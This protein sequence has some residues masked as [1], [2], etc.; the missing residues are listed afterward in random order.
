MTRWTEQ[1]TAFLRNHYHADMS[2]AVI[3]EQL[4]ISRNAV[5]GKAR[6]LGL[7]PTEDSPE[8]ITKL[9]KPVK[10]KKQRRKRLPRKDPL[11]DEIANRYR[12]GERPS[13]IAA[14]LGVSDE[15]VQSVRIGRKIPPQRDNSSHRKIT[16]S[17]WQMIREAWER[18]DSVESIAERLGGISENS[19]RQRLFQAG[20]R[21]VQAVARYAA[22]CTPAQKEILLHQGEAAFIAAMKASDEAERV[23]LQ[24]AKA[25]RRE[26]NK[27]S[28]RHAVKQAERNG[29]F[30][31]MSR[32][33]IIRW[34][35]E[36]A[37]L[38]LQEIGDEYGVTRE[39]I[40]Q[41]CGGKKWRALS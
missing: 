4:G 13:V 39:R 28:A 27:R 32:N 10:R 34:K 17:E 36:V 15:F 30:D 16:P 22:R 9:P 3:G 31:G 18:Y 37:G 19:L 11:R 40:R 33:E 29:T 38:T 6:R 5:I 21:R 7:A 41:L 14:D 8:K 1:D 12:A 24:E 20:F 35:R 25:V 2:A 26:I 23:A